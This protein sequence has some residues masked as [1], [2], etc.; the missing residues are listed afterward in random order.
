[1]NVNQPREVT[2]AIEQLRAEIEQLPQDK[3]GKRKGVSDDLKRRAAAVLSSS[4]MRLDDFARAISVSGSAM[5]SWRSQFRSN[6]NLIPNSKKQLI[7]PGFKKVSLTPDPKLTSRGITI[8]GPN[9]IR[10]TGLSASEVALLWRS[11][12]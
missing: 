9:G 6:L 5:N 11:L 4:G 2:A 3:G 1:M 8:E 10:I 12:C 7:D